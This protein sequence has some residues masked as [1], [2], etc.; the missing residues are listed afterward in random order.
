MKT[1]LFDGFL[2]QDVDVD[3]ATIHA[4]VGG[5]GPA[6]LL[7][8]GHPQTHAMWNRI[9]PALA[10]HFTVIAADLRGYGDSSRPAPG[11]ESVAYSKRIMARDMVDLM[12]HFGHESFFLGAHDRGARV[13]HR[14]LLD[15]PRRV[16][17]ALLL[18]I[19]PTL[20]MFEGTTEAFARAYWHW[21]FLIQPAPL[22]ERLIEADPVAYVR[23]VMGR[24]HAG[25]STFVPAAL[26][27]YERCIALPGT[28]GGICGDYRA[29]AGIDLVHDREDR[30]NQSRVN[31]P[32]RVL[33]G[34]HGAV[35][36]NF[37]ALALW[38]DA[39]TQ[40]SGRALDCGHY[41]AEERPDEVL[42]EMRAFFA[43]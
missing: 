1:Q 30:A 42:A 2:A 33:W 12:T 21:F 7:L 43:A 5:H 38:R 17:R 23:E 31:T 36:R 22:P 41:L 20:A 34:A 14:L 39:A 8:H 25:L 26:A 6:L 18:D 24:R 15:H 27:E 28:A 9:A 35:G 4:R 32:L 29:S 11:A 19:A 16:R 3:G 40:V 10:E 13:A 37:D